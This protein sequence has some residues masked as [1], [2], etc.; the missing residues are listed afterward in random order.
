MIVF[1]FLF[2]KACDDVSSALKNHKNMESLIKLLQRYSHVSDSCDICLR[3][4]TVFFFLA[5]RKAHQLLHT[6]LAYADDS[7]AEDVL[8]QMISEGNRKKKKD[9]M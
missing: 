3:Q 4:G 5:I 6:H 8:Q 2:K 7:I 9:L 1:L